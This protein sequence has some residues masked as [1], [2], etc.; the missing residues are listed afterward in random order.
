MSDFLGQSELQS[1]SHDK[2][3]Q[4]NDDNAAKY[5]KM[6]ES[7]LKMAKK[8]NHF[9]EMQKA[10][11][12]MMAKRGEEVRLRRSERIKRAEENARLEFAVT[13]KEQIRKEHRK[14]E[15][16]EKQLIK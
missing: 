16:Y 5:S 15:K 12:R 14:N 4:L 9:K 7:G 13:S 8:R 6:G 2:R 10:S 11:L 3:N 1:E